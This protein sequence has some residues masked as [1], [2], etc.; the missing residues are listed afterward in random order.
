M[1]SFVPLTFILAGLSLSCTPSQSETTLPD[2]G[3][4]IFVHCPDMSEIQC[5]T[6]IGKQ[7]K[8][9]FEVVRKDQPNY[10]D[11]DML[12]SCQDKFTK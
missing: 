11:W 1:K 9:G 10:S 5:E 7:C 8:Y 3:R 4:A 12:A 6:Y 2:G